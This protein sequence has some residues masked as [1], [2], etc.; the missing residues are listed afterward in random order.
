MAVGDGTDVPEWQELAK[1]RVN[2]RKVLKSTKA[3]DS[4]WS[5]MSNSR[6]T[7]SPSISASN[8]Q[9]NLYSAGLALFIGGLV[10]DVVGLLI[11]PD[12]NGNKA[13]PGYFTMVIEAIMQVTGLIMLTQADLDANN[14]FKHHR[15][16][17]KLFTFSWAL[18]YVIFFLGSMTEG[19][20]GLGFVLEA[21][22]LGYLFYRFTPIVEMEK[23]YKRTT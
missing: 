22:P 7:M 4:R 15:A 6:T 1:D 19:G 16:R 5:F 11:D 8:T 18:Y 14:Y 17:L 12:G 9:G 10:V 20:L 2:W 13:D 23:G 3:C 21:F